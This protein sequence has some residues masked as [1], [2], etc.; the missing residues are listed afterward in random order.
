[1]IDRTNPLIEIRAQ[2]ITD[3]AKSKI[4]TGSFTDS[5]LAVHA[6]PGND[7]WFHAVLHRMFYKQRC[8]R[9]SLVALSLTSKWL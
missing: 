6:C 1:M 3:Y 4:N 9:S 5:V 2:W 7:S 8:R